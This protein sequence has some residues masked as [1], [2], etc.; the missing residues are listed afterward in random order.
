[1]KTT[2]QKTEVNTKT[3]TAQDNGKVRTTDVIKKLAQIKSNSKEELAKKVV[4]HLKDKGVTKNSK[5]NPIEV[6][7]ITSLITAMCRDIKQPRK[8][9][10]SSWEVVDENN[11]FIMKEKVSN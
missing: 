3:T 11:S 7:N 1:M 10:W 6:S 5:G 8:G 9:W 4:Q 2:N